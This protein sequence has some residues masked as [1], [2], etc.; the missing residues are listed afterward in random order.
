MRKKHEAKNE[1]HDAQQDTC[2]PLMTKTERISY[3]EPL[4]AKELD[5]QIPVNNKVKNKSAKQKKDQKL[6]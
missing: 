4:I 2:V 1:E 5:A 6:L 3:S